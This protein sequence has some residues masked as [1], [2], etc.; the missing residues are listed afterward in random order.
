M[1]HSFKWK[2][3]VFSGEIFTC[4]GLFLSIISKWGGKNHPTWNNFWLLNRFFSPLPKDCFLGL[5]CLLECAFFGFDWGEVMWSIP[6]SSWELGGYVAGGRLR[7]HLKSA[8]N[9]QKLEKNLHS[10]MKMGCSSPVTS[11]NNQVC[12][13]WTICV[14][15]EVKNVNSPLQSCLTSVFP[16]GKTCRSIYYETLN[17]I[18]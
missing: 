8:R 9:R 1:L 4:W 12:W 3:W 7:Q 13:F 5:V 18:S 15:P 10:T 17:K 16:A 14:K 11:R 2:P 6:K